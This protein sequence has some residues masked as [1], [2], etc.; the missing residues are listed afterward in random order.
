MVVSLAT[1]KSN[2]TGT[3]FQLKF[4]FSDFSF[5]VILKQVRVFPFETLTSGPPPSA[6]FK[7]NNC[8]RGRLCLIVVYLC[9]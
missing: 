7:M 3:T 6:K 4:V 1:V 8:R 5:V 9:V 2:P